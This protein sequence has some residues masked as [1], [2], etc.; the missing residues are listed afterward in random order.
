MTK[1]ESGH[2]ALE[3]VT[4]HHVRVPLVEPAIELGEQG[5][6]HLPGGAGTGF[7]AARK[8]I[9]KYRVATQAFRR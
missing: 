8:K 9:E 5:F 7:H 6:I 1:S 3:G 4:L 2:L